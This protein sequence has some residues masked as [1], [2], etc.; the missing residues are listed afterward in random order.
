MNSDLGEKSVLK[1]CTCKS[2]THYG[3][4]DDSVI[5]ETNLKVFVDLEGTRIETSGK[6]HRSWEQEREC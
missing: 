2:S 4:I 5:D 3:I 6:L 1:F